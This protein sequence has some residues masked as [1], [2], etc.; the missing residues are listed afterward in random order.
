MSLAS[1]HFYEETQANRRKQIFP[2]WDVS[3]L[4]AEIFPFFIYESE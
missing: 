2:Q 3:S 1:P 4:K